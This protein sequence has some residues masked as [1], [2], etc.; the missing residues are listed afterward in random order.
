VLQKPGAMFGDRAAE[1]MKRVGQGTTWAFK[2][3]DC[4]KAC[5]E[6]QKKGVTILSPPQDLGFAVEAIFADLYGNS[7][8]LMQPAV[9]K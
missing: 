8:I 2:V 3:D 9:G 1:M 7:F 4:K 5:D 6:L